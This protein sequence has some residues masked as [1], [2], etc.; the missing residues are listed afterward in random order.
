MTKRVAQIDPPIMCDLS[1]IPLDQRA[2]HAALA[3]SLFG[4]EHAVV[5]RPDGLAVTLPS[6]RLADVVSFIGNER[7]CCR[8]L[9]FSIDVPASLA[10]LTLRV[11][12]P[13]AIDELRAL[14]R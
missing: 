8:H 14:C 13:G 10:P 11:V 9:A 2:S 1:A 6:D 12:G 3:R 5:E 7:R 4:G